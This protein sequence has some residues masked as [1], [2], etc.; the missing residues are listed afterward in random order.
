MS[1]QRVLILL[2]GAIILFALALIA[3]GSRPAAASLPKAHSID[4]AGF[5]LNL[6]CGIKVPGGLAQ[7]GSQAS[8]CKNCHE[9]KGEDSVNA[10]DDWHVSHA[11]GD[12][13][14]FCHGGNVQAPDKATA[15]QGLVNPLGDVKTN[16]VAC[17]E[18]YDAK[19]QVYA[20]ALGVTVG[21]DTGGSTQPPATGDAGGSTQPPAGSDPSGTTS[22]ETAPLPSGTTIVD[23]TRP[24]GQTEVAPIRAGNLIVGGLLALTVIGGGAFIYWNEKRLRIAYRGSPIAYRGLPKSEVEVGITDINQLSPDVQKLLPTLQSLD[25]RTL[26]ALKIIL[27]D[28]KRGE[29]LLQSL[30]VINF[31]VLEE[32]KRL[33]KRELSVLLALASEA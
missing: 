12:F 14:E 31:A 11:F 10:K 22:T 8:S 24:A 28:R 2:I 27:S 32:M 30:S 23:Y 25:P 33:D 6:Q 7:C 17:H 29:E 15:H 26:R 18:D 5:D 3:G 1:R 4:S 16:C 9:V 19:A 21:A 20:T 13:C